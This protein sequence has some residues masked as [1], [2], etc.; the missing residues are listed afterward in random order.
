MGDVTEGGAKGVRVMAV[1]APKKREFQDQNADDVEEAQRV[2]LSEKIRHHL[3]YFMSKDTFF[4][5]LALR[6]T[7]R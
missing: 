5:H 7:S 2:F 3:S 1:M 4:G 6:P